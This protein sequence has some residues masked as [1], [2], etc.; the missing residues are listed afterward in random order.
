MQVGSCCW[1]ECSFPQLFGE[2]HD[3]LSGQA[4]VCWVSAF[5]LR[6]LQL[7]PLLSIFQLNCYCL[8]NFTSACELT[9]TW[10][11]PTCFLVARQECSKQH[12]AKASQLYYSTGKPWVTGTW[13]SGLLF[14]IWKLAAHSHQSKG[15]GILL[16]FVWHID[17]CHTDHLHLGGVRV[18][19]H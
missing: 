18:N 9:F 2:N 10:H 13:T 15:K 12:S 6:V 1:G 3:P 7:L 17:W 8:Y 16:L 19:Y 4:A 14:S 11:E 5:F